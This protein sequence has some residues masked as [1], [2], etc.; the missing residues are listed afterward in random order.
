VREPSP[1]LRLVD[2]D[3]LQ[4]L[5]EVVCQPPRTLFLV[6]EDEHGDAACLPVAHG[7]EDDRP[8]EGASRCFERLRDAAHVL[9]W[10]MSEE[11]ERDVK[12]AR[13]DEPGITAQ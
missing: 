3:A 13:L 12:V 7:T 11:G 5:V 6:R 9:D 1:F 4:S 8:G 2:P 10:A